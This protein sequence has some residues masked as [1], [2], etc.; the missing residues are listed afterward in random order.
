MRRRRCA[1]SS[2]D[3]R[4]AEYCDETRAKGWLADGRGR[5]SDESVRMVEEQNMSPSR[6][7]PRC[8]RARA[9]RADFFIREL[10]TE[11]VHV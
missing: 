2:D 8:W 10:L 3:V 1:G 5:V 7:T 4:D 9:C 6:E 11:C